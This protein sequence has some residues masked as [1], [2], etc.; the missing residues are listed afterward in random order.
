MN[1]HEI[2]IQGTSDIEFPLK[3]DKDVS[4]VFKR[5]GIDSIRKK[6]LGDGSFKYTYTLINSDII[7]IIEEDRIQT[8][9]TKK[10]SQR[11][12]NALHYLSTEKGIDDEEFYDKFISRI[13]VPDNLAKTSDLL[14]LE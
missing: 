7:T 12:R 13:C 5:L 14:G 11:L 10:H 3:D 1:I 2:R 4:A 6:P 9:K 8:G